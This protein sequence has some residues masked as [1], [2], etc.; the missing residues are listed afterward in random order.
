MYQKIAKHPNVRLIYRKQLI[1]EGS[2]TEE[3][4]K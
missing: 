2:V 4:A 3:E 1:D